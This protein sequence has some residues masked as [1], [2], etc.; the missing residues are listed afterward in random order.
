MLQCNFAMLCFPAIQNSEMCDSQ[1]TGSHIQT[2]SVNTR[3][4]II[5]TLKCLEVIDSPAFHIK[6]NAVYKAE[7]LLTLDYR[8]K[9]WRDT[10][11]Y[12]EKTNS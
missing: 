9:D 6:D 1:L 12:E 8:N 7:E 5:Y 10:L 3:F 11:K 2:F 4:E